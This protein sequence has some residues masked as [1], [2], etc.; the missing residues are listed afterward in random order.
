MHCSQ[1]W[2]SGSSAQLLR[3]GG[4]RTTCCHCVV[5]PVPVAACSRLQLEWPASRAA[6]ES[7]GLR[8]SNLSQGGPTCGWSPL[9]LTDTG[10]ESRNRSSHTSSAGD[11]GK[12]GALGETAAAPGA[13]EVGLQKAQG[14]FLRMLIAAR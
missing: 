6:E 10:W 5:P 8:H 9:R 12:W 1:G 11:S 7:P 4:Q 14:R 2:L 3:A 13:E